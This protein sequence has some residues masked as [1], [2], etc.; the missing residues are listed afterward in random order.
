M[1]VLV[2]HLGVSP[3][4]KIPEAV[5]H[6]DD[7]LRLAA[8][9][10]IAVKATG[11]PSMATDAYPF[12]STHYVLRRVFEAFGPRRVFWGTDITRLAPSWLQYITQFTEE[13]PR[14]TG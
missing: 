11:I 4:L 6:L 1:R 5:A 2:D 9:A 3:V 8:H 12:A 10:N 13:V 14:L 7:L